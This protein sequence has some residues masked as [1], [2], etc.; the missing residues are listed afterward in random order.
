MTERNRI[1]RWTVLMLLLL[2]GMRLLSQV[3]GPLRLPE[4]PGETIDLYS[5]RS[6]YAA[7][8]QIFYAAR[9]RK[10]P[11][12]PEPDWS[13]VLYAELIRWDGTKLASSTAAIDNGYAAG[14]LR[15][16][17]NIRSGNYYLRAYTKWMRNYSPYSYTYLTIRIV[18]PHTDLIDEGPERDAGSPGTKVSGH[19]ELSE[20]IVISKLQGSY[21]KRQLVE[22]EIALQDSALP[23]RYCLSVAKAG[24]A[25]PLNLSFRYAGPDEAAMR[26][27]IEYLPEISGPAVSGRVIDTRSGEPA[28]NRKIN[29]SSYSSSFYFSS[30]TSGQDGSFV[31]VLPNYKGSHEFHVAIGDDGSEAC[32]ILVSSEFCNRPVI[33]PYIPFHLEDRERETARELVLNAQL[34]RR[35]HQEDSPLKR[36]DRIWPAFYGVPVSTISENDFI[37]LDNLKE[38]FYELVYNVSVGYQERKPYLVVRGPTSLSQY[39]PLILVDNIAV[40]N[41]EKLLSI[42]CRRINRI[43]VINEGYVI[44]DFKYSGIISIFSEEKD[45]AADLLDKRQFFN[46]QLFS[47]NEFSSPDY[48][49]ESGRSSLP[50]RRNVLFWEPL[51]ELEGRGSARI[52]FYTSDEAGDFEILLRGPGPGESTVVYRTSRFTV[53]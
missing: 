13:S 53:R 21:G 45:L 11:Q 14:S 4:N 18:N 23:G 5:D 33:L 10:P 46:Y 36:E 7:S 8:E 17:D 24:S 1:P 51:L 50:D 52:R 31:F 43:E 41:D 30:V 27:G 20:A 32:E 12:A 16:P 44:G 48:S 15:I 37:E 35:F 49:G 29:L 3:P 39:P 19:A 40:A 6:L 28:R 9:Y 2:E 25:D 47:E 22:F 34:S 38:F 26:S 42:A